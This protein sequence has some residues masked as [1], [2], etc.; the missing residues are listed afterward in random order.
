MKKLYPWE[1]TVFAFS[2]GAIV[3]L[4][5]VGFYLVKIKIPPASKPLI[6]AGHAHGL[7]FAFAAIFYV[8]L[9]GKVNISQNFKKILAYLLLVTF[10]GPFGLLFAG[11]T[12][13]TSLL[14]LT[15]IVGEG[16]FVFLWLILFFAFLRS[17]N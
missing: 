15:S 17:K 8:L 9:L 14:P 13:Q 4:S 10:L 6:K 5:L 7:C 3:V 16:S 11:F 1:K 2:A 12:Q